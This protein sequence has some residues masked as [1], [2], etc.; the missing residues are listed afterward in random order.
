MLLGASAPPK[1][2]TSFSCSSVNKTTSWSAVYIT[3]EVILDKVNIKST[4]HQPDCLCLVLLGS[5]VTAVLIFCTCFRFRGH[6]DSLS[7]ST[8]MMVYIWLGLALVLV[9]C[10]LTEAATPFRARTYTVPYP[11]DTQVYTL[12][13]TSTRRA[14][15]HKRRISSV[16]CTLGLHTHNFTFPW[17]PDSS[18]SGLLGEQSS[19]E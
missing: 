17:L 19:P 8:T 2:V 15:F 7:A 4:F 13:P 10:S 14:I 12:Q 1:R 18:D 16:T 5:A 9:H 11:L 6:A 3:D